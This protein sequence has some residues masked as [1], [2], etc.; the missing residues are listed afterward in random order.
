MNII[1]DILKLGV[2]LR[3][4]ML[5]FVLTFELFASMIL[6]LNV[7]EHP[8]KVDLILNFDAPYT[9]AIIKKRSKERIDL[10]LKKVTLLAPWQKKLSSKLVYQI[11]ATPVKNGAMISF[12]T[13]TNP[14][15]LAAKSKDGYSLKITLFSKEAIDRSKPS[16]SSFANLFHK[17]PFK[18]IGI[19]LLGT[20]VLILAF[21]FL[22]KILSKSGSRVKETK[23]II[24]E[25][26]QTETFKILFEKP[27]DEKNKIALIEHNG[28]QYLVIIGSTNVLLGKYKEGEIDSHEEFEKA[29]EEQNIQ[30]ALKPKPQ[31]EIFTTIEEYKRRASGDI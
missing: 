7:K 17:I 19:F 4:L 23:R 25:N 20:L 30:E 16:T 21:L 31:D 29:I 15:L 22:I 11:N 6:N 10:L 8:N 14:S 13:T 24:V 18:K 3:S 26:P 27:L 12:Y 28:I 2:K 5:I 9:G 1:K